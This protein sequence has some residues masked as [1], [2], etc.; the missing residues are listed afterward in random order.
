MDDEVKAVREQIERL[1][2]EIKKTLIAYRYP[3][4][5]NEQ[6]FQS[7]VAEVLVMAGF[8]APREVIADRG[9]Y[10]IEVERDGVRV[11][12]ELKIK[13]SAAEAERQCQRYA[14][15]ADV[16]A[17]ILVTTSHRLA[18]D[19]AAGSRDRSLAGHDGTRK[20]FELVLVRSAL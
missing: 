9:R 5:H 12:L 17:V 14:M 13:G 3:N 2:D 10:D 6:R 8:R 7:A 11:V 20:P 1:V 19:V 4:C 15:T 18:S 16:H